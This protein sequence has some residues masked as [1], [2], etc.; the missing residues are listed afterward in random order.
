MRAVLVLLLMCSSPARGAAQE[1]PIALWMTHDD[2]LAEHLAP[3]RAELL[4]SLPEASMVSGNDCDPEGDAACVAHLLGAAHE[5]WVARIVWQRGPCVP[6]VRDG[7]R[8]GSRMLRTAV[9]VLERYASDG[10]LIDSR[11]VSIERGDLA[12]VIR[13]MRRLALGSPA[14]RGEALRSGTSR[15]RA[16]RP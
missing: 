16:L 4:D 9:V 10:S 2:A 13:S 3:V 1:R 11:S 6:I 7:E 12:E 5:L 15:G 8:T 14:T